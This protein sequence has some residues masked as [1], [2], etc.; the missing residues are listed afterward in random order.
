MANGKNQPSY[1]YETL[2]HRLLGNKKELKPYYETL[3]LEQGQDLFIMHKELKALREQLAVREADAKNARTR[4]ENISAEFSER[5]LELMRREI[6]YSSLS[7]GE[8]KEFDKQFPISSLDMVIEARDANTAAIL[9][10][11]EIQRLANEKVDRITAYLNAADATAVVANNLLQ[12]PNFS[13]AFELNG[14]SG[15]GN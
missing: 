8:K 14:R 9:A 12:D 1:T 7:P 3:T 10:L 4:Y 13:S 6:E 15:K 11:R 2:G 5:E